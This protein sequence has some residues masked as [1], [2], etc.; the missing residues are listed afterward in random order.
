MEDI[1]ECPI[2]KC[3]GEGRYF[4]NGSSYENVRTQKSGLCNVNDIVI[5]HNLKI[6][7]EV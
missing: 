3:N 2:Q 1:F 6:S 5:K 4:F 7:E